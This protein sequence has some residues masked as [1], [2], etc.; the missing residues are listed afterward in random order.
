MA[1]AYGHVK[2][3]QFVKPQ[4]Q[5]GV[6]GQLR[7]LSDTDWADSLSAT[8]FSQDTNIAEAPSY[9]RSKTHNFT[10]DLSGG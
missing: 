4:R 5:E 3:D 6:I 1:D 2:T 8:I 9:A 10:P 7:M